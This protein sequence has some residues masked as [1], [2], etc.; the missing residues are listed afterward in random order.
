MEARYGRPFTQQ[1][2]AEVKKGKP[3]IETQNYQPGT[4]PSPGELTAKGYRLGW[5]VRGNAGIEVENW[6]HPSGKSIQRDVSTWKPGA[7]QLGEQPEG[8]AGEVQSVDLPPSRLDPLIDKQEKAEVLL[9]RLQDN[10]NQIKDLLNSHPV[11]WDEVKQRFTESND[12]QAELKELGASSD[13][14]SA[15]PT[16]DMDDVDENFY[17]QLDAARQD[18]LDL[19]VDADNQNPDFETLMQQP[20]TVVQQ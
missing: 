12:L 13:D 8:H 18:L 4:G 11:P 7:A 15:A 2:L 17:Q 10:N 3:Q 16:L 19:R 6:V 9:S 1:F 5:K 20:T 14:P